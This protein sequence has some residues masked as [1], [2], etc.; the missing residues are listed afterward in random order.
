MSKLLDNINQEIPDRFYDFTHEYQQ[1]IL[2]MLI[3][4]RTFLIQSIELIKPKYFLSETHRAICASLFEY[5]KNYSQLPT[6]KVLVNSLK[7]KFGEDYW[8]HVAE[9][10]YIV[11]GFQPGVDSREQCLDKITQFA[12]VRALEQAIVQALPLMKKKDTN[13]KEWKKI[14]ELFNNA[15]ITDRNFD[16]GLDYFTTLNDRFNR[17]EEQDQKKEV[18]ITGFD[19]LDQGLTMG[20]LGRGEIGSFMAM[21]GAG[22]S[23]MLVKVAVRNIVRGKKVLFIS[24][25]MDQ[26]KIA[27]RFDTIFA[28]CGMTDLW[29]DKDNIIPKI[30][31]VVDDETDKS[32]LVVKQFPA[33]AAD[34]NTLRLF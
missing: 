26:D 14:T 27:K 25:E 29:K 10:E 17:M 20:G 22:K 18:F 5:F 6:R 3:S 15:L 4:D 1:D 16:I 30:N 24:L 11:S 12:K 19:G 9:L 13:E 23:W 34:V 28:L 8:D 33:G 2:G 31:S 7:E 21:P 32:R